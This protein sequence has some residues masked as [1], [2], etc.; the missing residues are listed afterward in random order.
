MSPK[1]LANNMYQ[2]EE[3]ESLRDHWDPS[4]VIRAPEIVRE[5]EIEVEGEQFKVYQGRQLTVSV[6]ANNIIEA[7]KRS[8][9][10]EG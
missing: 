3:E 1:H 4:M 2:L 7:I 5:G 10:P 8:M 9:R 6:N